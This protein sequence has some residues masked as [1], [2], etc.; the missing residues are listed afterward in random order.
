RPAGPEMWVRIYPDDCLI[1]TFEPTL[2]GSEIAAA[3]RYYIESW[4]AGGVET[5]ERAAWRGLVGS[6]GAGRA[7]WII[8][9]FSPL[10]PADKPVKADAN[11]VV[12]VIATDQ[13]L[14]LPQPAIFAYWQAVWAAKGDAAQL[15]TAYQNLLAAAGG[16]AALAEQVVQNFAPDNIRAWAGSDQPAASVVVL[17][18]TPYP[19]LDTKN[20]SWTQAPKVN[21]FPDRFV[22]V[23]HNT[24]QEPVTQL[25]APITLPL[26]V[27]PDPANA[28]Q[29]IENDGDLDLG[30][31]IRWMTDFEAAVEKGLGLRVALSPQQFA[32][33]FERLFVIGI[34]LSADPDK[35]AAD[36]EQLLQHHLYSRSG[37]A[38]VPQ[39]TPT[40]N[41]EESSSAFNRTDDADDSYD[42]FVKN[43]TQYTL[44]TA[45]D[46]KSD[47][48]WFAESL[49]LAPTALQQTPNAGQP[50]QCEARA[51]NT[52]LW[53]ATWGYYFEKM[54]HPVLGKSDIR[55][56]RQF[57]KE[58]VSARGPVPALRIGRQPYGVLPVAPFRSLG[59]IKQLDASRD[60]PYLSRLYQL[61]L[62]LDD[63]W[64]ELAAKIPQ[65]GQ[66]NDKDP[67]GTLLNILGL[68]PGAEEIH[69]ILGEPYYVS[70]NVAALNGIEGAQNVKQ[71]PDAAGGQFLQDLGYTGYDIPEI[72]M[73]S[74]FGHPV[75]LHKQV[76]D[77]VPL[78][79]T[80]PVR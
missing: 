11:E 36:L 46:R 26:T 64:R 27:G 18:F 17:N 5:Q 53:P 31:D 50:D 78:S 42:V 16:D 7:A 74:Y 33:G 61:L 4:K 57:F 62:Q 38:L 15:N 40:N 30:D 47:G 10:N 49:G 75:P 48:Q 45:P 71:T 8:Q 69:T 58:F 14:P 55:A 72:L 35:N 6:T 54:L 43:A 66:A 34:R 22:L 56:T 25:F 70:Y 68:H 1:D 65:V 21:L 39:G 19:D 51:M 28:Q 60:N 67:Q 76:V 3:R 80:A 32:Q 77:D 13:P 79:E 20:F 44:E 63:I 52:A 73:R 24:G 59:W 41:T 29:F 9:H 2:S 12:L 37:F 23:G